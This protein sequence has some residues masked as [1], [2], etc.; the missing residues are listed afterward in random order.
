MKKK[1]NEKKTFKKNM[2]N[3]NRKSAL[4]KITFRKLTSK[5][6]ELKKVIAFK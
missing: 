2:E 5:K 3:L 6:S 1:K 4:G